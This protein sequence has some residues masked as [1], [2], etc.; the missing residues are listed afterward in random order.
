MATGLTATSYTNTG[1]TNGTTYD[2]VVSASNAAGE[3]ANSAQASAT[4][5]GTT[6]ASLTLQYKAAD[7]NAADSQIKPHFR[8]MNNGTTA[9]PLSGVKIR[10][11]Y[12]SDGTQPQTAECDY[13]QV[14]CTNINLT[15]TTLATPRTGADTY[16][17]L[18]FSAGA[19]SIAGGGNSGEMQMRIHRN[20]WTNYNETG[21]YS[22]D[23]TKTAFA[24]WNN[25]TV[26]VDGVLVW[27]T[28]P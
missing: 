1:L 17:E 23:P 12:T 13:A 4:P 6:A 10:Y 7:T 11:W 19:G 22:F 27:G 26:Y 9:V 18:S 8:L 3:S 21:D 20:D 14:G 24:D 16:L 25:V 28:E 15:I 2:Y 5:T